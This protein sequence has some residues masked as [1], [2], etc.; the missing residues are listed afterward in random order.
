MTQPSPVEIAKRLEAFIRENFQVAPDDELFSRSINLWEEGYVD[1]V[2]VVE[3][4]AWLEAT[5]EL[6][7]PETVLFDPNFT[8]ISGMAE[9]LGALV[10]GRTPP[11]QGERD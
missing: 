7:I 4:I 6:D 3:V 5:Y 8:S 2:G 10:N 1:S 11:T 9:H